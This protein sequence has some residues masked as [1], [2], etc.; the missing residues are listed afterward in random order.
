MSYIVA[1][2]YWNDLC[3]VD[4]VPVIKSEDAFRLLPGMLEIFVRLTKRTEKE[5]EELQKKVEELK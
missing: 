2:A 1:S 3:K 5:L 4:S